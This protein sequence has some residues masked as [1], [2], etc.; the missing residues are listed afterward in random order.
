M[1]I[2]LR[3]DIGWLDLARAFTYCLIPG[4]RSAIMQ[5]AMQSWSPQN[6][7][8]IT[9][10]V[11]SAF[12]LLL[13]A[14]QLPK[15]SEVL[16]S[17]LTVPDMARIVELHGLI[18]VPID[19]D[20]AGNIDSRSIARVIS[21]QSRVIVIAHLFGGWT[22]LTEV[23]DLAQRN[24]LLVVEDCAQS[25]SRVGE[26]GHQSADA[27]M[28]SFGPIKTATALGGGIVRIKSPELRERMTL[29][30]ESDPLQSRLSFVQRVARFAAIKML[31]GERTSA[32]LKY[33]M[34]SVGLDFDSMANTMV[35]GFASSNLL[36]QL[37][38]QPS[39][40]LLRLLRRRW[41]SYDFTRIK[42]RTDMGR[43][44][45]LSL[46]Y[47]HTSAH[48]FWVYPIFVRNPNEV[49]GRLRAA[50]F[51]ATCQARMTVVSPT[52]E[53]NQPVLAASMWKHVI[54]LPWYPDIPQQ[55]VEKMASLIRASDLIG[56]EDFS[57]E[58][59][60]LSHPVPEDV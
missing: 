18:P 19:T 52:N 45:D 46:G 42:S 50:G 15:G 30:L 27:A 43:Y 56:H 29:L 14:L 16:L 17:A 20:E 1:W 58:I 13:R 3:L 9:L 24:N 35:R 44:L 37:R 55:A 26:S 22:D 57:L 28:F 49:C 54:F 4:Q 2:R 11:R 47:A 5:Q 8:L 6:D 53:L 51:D 10:S 59:E 21:S 32:L 40:P 36:R 41:L 48:S 31:S 7:F 23:I 38:R 12:D 39:T 34:E 33:C 25:F 60:Y